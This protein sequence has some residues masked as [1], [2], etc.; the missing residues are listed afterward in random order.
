MS[1]HKQ[2]IT[3]R[4]RKIICDLS[5]AL[6]IMLEDYLWSK[7][8]NENNYNK[9]FVLS[10]NI[11]KNIYIKVQSFGFSIASACFWFFLA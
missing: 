5:H 10:Q 11:D 3:G 8:N 7:I 2:F 9:I 6:K 1:I 4:E